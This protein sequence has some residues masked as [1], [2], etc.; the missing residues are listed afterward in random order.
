M[1]DISENLMPDIHAPMLNSS[2]QAQRRIPLK[3]KPTVPPVLLAAISLTALM[4]CLETIAIRSASGQTPHTTKPAK[5]TIPLTWD[6][7]AI[8][9]LEVP[10]A[11][12]IG[13]PKHISADYYYRIPVRPIYKQYPVY[14]PGREPAGYIDWLKKQNPIVLWD[15][16]NRKPKLETEA[17]WVKAGEDVFSAPLFTDASDQAFIAISDIKTIAWYQKSGIPI[18]KD[19][20]LPF[21]HYVIREKGKIELGSFSCAMCHTRVMPDGTTLKGAQGNFPFERSGKYSPR[22]PLP[23]PLLHAFNQGLYAAPWLHPDPMD[24]E[25]SM[26]S[27]QINEILQTIPPGVIS[28]H[29]SSN[30][31]PVQV[32]DLIGVKDR[33]YLDRTGLQPQNS[34]VDL[35][36]YAALNQGGDMLASFDGFIPAD[37]PD[38]K[39]LPDPSDPIKVGGRYSDEQL[40]ALALY[41]YS[42]KPP[43]NPNKFDAAAA[44][45][46]QVFADEGCSRCHTAPLY[47]NNKLT[48]AAG[49]IVPEDERVKYDISPISVGT[50]PSL[51]LNTRRGTGYYKVPSLKGVWYRSMFGHSGWCATIEDWFD[52]KRLNEDYIPTG[53][54]PYGAKTY[55]VKGHNFGLDLTPQE[56][57][58]LIAFLKTL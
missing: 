15:D 7:S 55:A 20:V 33:R 12:P 36:R 6:D 31:D 13:S 9:A 58:D 16:A 50:D 14:A 27:E 42:L 43:P 29:R 32:P 57:Q 8:S 10:L 52:P 24:R 4:V 49:F 1:R 47:T 38:F 46:K 5:P 23:A 54:K 37:I 2:G 26:S 48:P 34:L 53:F 39:K 25:M 44:R 51:T 21:V 19:G 56:R 35:M 28:R 40:Y 17:D 41:I 11:H 30:F 22:P 3:T 45:G 18:S